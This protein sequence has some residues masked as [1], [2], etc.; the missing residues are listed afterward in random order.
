MAYASF[1]DL[2]AR[3]DVRVIAKYASDT[4]TPVTVPSLPTN[5]RVVAALRDAS[6]M[7]RNALVKGK[8]YPS[9]V[10]DALAA[11]ADKGAVLIQMTCA[12]AMAQII[13]KAVAGVDEIEELVMGY[14]MALSNLEDLRNGKEVF[15]LDATLIATLPSVSGGPSATDLNRPTNWNPIFGSFERRF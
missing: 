15:D 1:N 13:G 6:G 8:R 9:A 11:D 4:G 5:A 3:Y 2:K 12:L 14:K 10:L 7:I